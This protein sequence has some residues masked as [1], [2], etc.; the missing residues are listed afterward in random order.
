MYKVS[1]VVFNVPTLTATVNIDYGVFE[2]VLEYWDDIVYDHFSRIEDA[3]NQKKNQNKEKLEEGYSYFPQSE[4]KTKDGKLTNYYPFAFKFRSIRD[5]SGSTMR[6]D[7]KAHGSSR[8]S[9]DTAYMD[10]DGSYENAQT[11]TR[12]ARLTSATASRRVQ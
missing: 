2:A 4:F 9:N 5:W 6:S 12:E 10:D 7:M 3:R 8:E 11:Y 1:E